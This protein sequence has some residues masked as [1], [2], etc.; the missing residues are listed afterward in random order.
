[1]S[2]AGRVSAI[3]TAYNSATYIDRAIASVLAQTRPVDELVV[4]DDGSHDDTRGVV[5]RYADAGV[6]YIY[7][8]NQGPSAARNRGL[9]ETTGEFVAFL[10]SDDQWL[11]DKTA[12][13]LAYCAAAPAAAVVSGPAIWWNPE[14]DRRWLKP[15][16]LRPG[17]DWH[18]ELLVRNVVGN[19]SQVLIRRAV[20]EASGPFS[21]ALVWGEEWELWLRLAAQAPIGF[22]AEPVIIYRLQVGGL[23]AK[24]RPEHIEQLLQ[25]CLQAIDR[26]PDE[27]RRPALR[28]QVRSGAALS[29]AHLAERRHRPPAEVRPHAW[30]AVHLDP[31]HNTGDKV[32]VLT[33]ALIPQWLYQ[34]YRRWLKDRPPG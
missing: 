1:M 3:I 26:Y 19:P 16:P 10:D 9:A 33:R 30:R 23:T 2:S 13:Q 25:A 17:Q 11:P 14:T 4:I 22:V 29:Q 28:R 6:R 20:I 21:T 24:R 12:Q 18:T 7:Q 32:K 8:S 15:I 34:F 27:R 5:A 31:W